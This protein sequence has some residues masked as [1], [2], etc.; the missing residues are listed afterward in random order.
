M[1]SQAE[2]AQ[3]IG[4]MAAHEA[5][6]GELYRLYAAK[7]PDSASLFESLAHAETDHARSLADFAEGVRKDLVHIDPKRFSAAAILSSL[8]YIRERLA[9]ANSSPV[10]LVEALSIAHDL[11]EGLIEK[12]YYEVADGDCAELKNLLQRLAQ[13]TAAHLAQVKTAW[14][15]ARQPTP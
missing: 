2:Q 8:D 4:L 15:A 14:S 1:S 13:E 11:E 6:I 12:R 9:E 5:A 7:L 10:I 3:T